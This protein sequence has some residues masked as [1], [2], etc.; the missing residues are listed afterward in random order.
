MSRSTRERLDDIVERTA[1]IGVA[2]RLLTSPDTGVAETAFDAVLYDL[3]VIGEAVKNLPDE[4]LERHP[5]IPWSEIA[6]MRDVL[7]HIYFRVRSEVVK[8]TIDEPLAAL[9]AACEAELARLS[10]GDA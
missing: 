10:R 8:A 7:A 2:E 5:D 1:R 4:V 9:K 3:V 6:K